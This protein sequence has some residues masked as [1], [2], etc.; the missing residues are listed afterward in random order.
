MKKTRILK[1]IIEWS[2]DLVTSQESTSL[3]AASRAEPQPPRG[4]DMGLATV[5]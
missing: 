5:T 2:R 4:P 3:R 1:D